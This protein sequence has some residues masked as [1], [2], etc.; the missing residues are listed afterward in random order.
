VIT[1]PV[2]VVCPRR[3]DYRGKPVLGSELEHCPTCQSEIWV[4]PSTPLTADRRCIQCAL[5]EFGPDVTI[6]VLPGQIEE[7]VVE[8]QRRGKL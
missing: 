2:T 8:L 3:G 7:F 5:Q 6:D 1:E 4:S